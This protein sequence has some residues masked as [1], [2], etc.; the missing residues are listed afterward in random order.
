MYQNR[1]IYAIVGKAS[2]LVTYRNEAFEY[3]STIQTPALFEI[4]QVAQDTSLR[5]LDF[6]QYNVTM[7]QF[8]FFTVMPGTGV[9]DI[10]NTG[11]VDYTKMKVSIVDLTAGYQD[12]V[13]RWQLEG[14]GDGLYNSSTY[15]FEQCDRSA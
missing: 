11:T 4:N 3:T 6:Y 10:A 5:S 9:N 7:Q 8:H 15:S 2:D 13:L 1:G 12:E 14:C